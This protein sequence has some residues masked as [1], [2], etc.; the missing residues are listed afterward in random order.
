MVEKKSV[1]EKVVETTF[2]KTSYLTTTLV[3]PWIACDWLHSLTLSYLCC[4]SALCLP[5]YLVVFFMP[6]NIYDTHWL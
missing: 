2:M 6:P 3:K 5:F 1:V 4:P